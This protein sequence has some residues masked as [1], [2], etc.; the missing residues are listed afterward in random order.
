MKRILGVAVLILWFAVPAH[1]Q[2]FGTSL[3]GGSLG[4]VSFHTLPSV[5]PAQFEVRAVSGG[6]DFVPSSYVP[7]EQ[8]LAEGRAALAARTKTLAEITRENS[9]VPR[10]KARLILVQ[11]DHGRAIL[12]RL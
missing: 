4:H 2:Y 3:G 5:P 1:A 8:A 9:V 6:A 12:A 11:D 10:V 7:Y